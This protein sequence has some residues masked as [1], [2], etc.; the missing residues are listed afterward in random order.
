MLTELIVKKFQVSGV[1]GSG[2]FG[3]PVLREVYLSIYL[4]NK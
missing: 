4:S 2:F 3:N 1:S